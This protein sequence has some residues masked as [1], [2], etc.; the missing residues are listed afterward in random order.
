MS[1]FGIKSRPLD[2]ASYYNCPDSCK[3][4]DQALIETDQ[5]I[6]MGKIVTDPIKVLPGFNASDLPSILRSPT[7]EDL[8]THSN[9]E[10]L[11]KRAFSFCQNRIQERN[12][13]MKLV[14]VEV[15]FDRSKLIF[16]KIRKGL[17]YVD[18]GTSSRIIK[19][20]EY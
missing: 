13:E 16:Y 9:N 19:G 20:R 18:K 2:F 12:L 14:E 3:K 10:A 7:H 4:G 11:R 17:N 6:F 8:E 1:V 15:F 5:G